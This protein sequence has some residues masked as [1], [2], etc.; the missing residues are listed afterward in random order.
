M[1]YKTC[2]TENYTCTKNYHTNTINSNS[3]VSIY[4]KVYGFLYL[5][6]AM[7]A[8]I[9]ITAK[10]AFWHSATTGTA[11]RCTVVEPEKPA[12]DYD[13]KVM[14]VVYLTNTACEKIGQVSNEENIEWMKRQGYR[15]F[16]IDYAHHEKS[17][18]PYINKDIIALNK[19]LNCGTFCGQDGISTERAYILFEGY[20]IRRDVAYFHDDP[21]VYNYPEEYSTMEGD[22]LFMDIIY[23]EKP[24][25]KVATL[26]SFSYSNSY[27][28]TAKEGYTEKYRHKRIFLGYTFAMFDDSFLEG[29][30]A[31]GVA[32][33]I[34]DHPKY[35]DWGRGNRKGGQ[36]KEYGSIEVNP[37]AAQKVRSAIRTLRAE[38]KTLGLNGEIALYGFSR[39]STAASL[40]IG[41][42]PMSEWSGTERGRF[43]E[44][45]AEISK[46]FL[47]PG[48]FDYSITSSDSR[49][50]RNMSVYCNTKQKT[51]KAWEQQGGAKAIKKKAV[52]CFLF[53]NSSD[54]AE[55]GRQM[56]NLR[57]ILE[58]TKTR[59]EIMVD[60][61]TGH[62]V[63]KE[64]EQLERMYRFL[65]TQ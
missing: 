62:S 9:P 58:R 38:G 10:A 40:A 2:T 43:P 26:L 24:T 46:A 13:G 21:K 30:P 27:A 1:I 56:D 35:C 16:V 44:E 29:A 17:I 15:I 23:P 36:Q 33:A 6:S 59:Y 34:A 53:Y 52:P 37:D 18:S 63:P 7:L 20:R 64:Q 11:L 12:S 19:A 55:Y 57:E 49:E 60:Y 28:G 51:E 14:T 48:I 54:D 32:W 22:S 4:N 50:Y 8:F 41:D 5:L 39:G 25:R 45:R 31:V 3:H 42:M 65:I 61:G 47:G